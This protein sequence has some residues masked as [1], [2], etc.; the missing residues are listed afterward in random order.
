MYQYKSDLNIFFLYLLDYKDNM[1]V[2]DVTDDDFYDFIAYRKR[3]GNRDV[4]LGRLWSVASSL[5]SYLVSRK[6]MDHNPASCIMNP[7]RTPFVLK[8]DDEQVHNKGKG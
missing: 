4:R 2:A 8:D 3:M 1:C 6:Y 5:F 7:A